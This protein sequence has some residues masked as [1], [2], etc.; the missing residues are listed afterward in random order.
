MSKDDDDFR[1]ASERAQR[2]LGELFDSLELTS[3]ETAAAER[4]ALAVMRMAEERYRRFVADGQTL[5][6]KCLIAGFAHAIAAAEIWAREVEKR[7]NPIC[8]RAG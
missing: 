5:S 7:E 2:H 8:G 6:P 4:L 3:E 1:R